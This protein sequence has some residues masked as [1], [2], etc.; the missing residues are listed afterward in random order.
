MKKR[1]TS[2]WV[3][4]GLALFA[5][6]FCASLAEAQL[7]RG[8]ITGTVTDQSGAAV[9]GAAITITN[10]DTGVARTSETGTTGRYE[11]PGLPAGNYEVSARLAG[12]QTSIRSGIA[13]TV[14]CGGKHNPA[15][16]RGSASRHGDRRSHFRRDDLCHGVPIGG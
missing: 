14:E 4:G 6:L 5:F 1:L 7:T 2:K 13:L 9:P 15:S 11:A 16:G 10:V 3:R 8:T 12:F